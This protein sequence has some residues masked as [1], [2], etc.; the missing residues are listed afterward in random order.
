MSPVRRRK[1]KK[2]KKRGGK[3]WLAGVDVLGKRGNRK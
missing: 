1:K 3:G 2:K